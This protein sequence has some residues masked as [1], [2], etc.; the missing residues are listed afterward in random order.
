MVI[1]QPNLAFK[2]NT[3]CTQC[4]VFSSETRILASEV[5]F[6]CYR[7]GSCSR[8]LVLSMHHRQP[9]MSFDSEFVQLEYYGEIDLNGKI[10]SKWDASDAMCVMIEGW[11]V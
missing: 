5:H 1:N 2:I 11:V 7:M 9:S 8:T 10:C 4:H 3:Y 6:L